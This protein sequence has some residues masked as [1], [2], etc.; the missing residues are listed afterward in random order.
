MISSRR[1][2]EVGQ[3]AVHRRGVEE[4]GAVLHREPQALRD[5]GGEEGQVEL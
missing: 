2:P 1:T 3:H 4:V 5:F